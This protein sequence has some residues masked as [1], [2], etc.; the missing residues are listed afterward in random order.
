MVR[1]RLPFA[2]ALTLSKS[3]DSRRPLKTDT[4]QAPSSV[5]IAAAE[6]TCPNVCEFSVVSIPEYC[7][8]LNTLFAVTRASNDRVSPSATVRDSEASTATIPGPSIDP[9]EAVPNP[10]AGVTNAAVLNQSNIVP[11]AGN[12]RCEKTLSAAANC[13]VPV[14]VSATVAE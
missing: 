10:F 9:R 3:I 4:A 1:L 8:V 14:A 5:R 7:T 2:I 11:V 13:Y 12:R 6:V